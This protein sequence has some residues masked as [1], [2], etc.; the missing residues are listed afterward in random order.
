M[1]KFEIEPA[2]YNNSN[3]NS[4]L[5]SLIR[6]FEEEGLVPCGARKRSAKQVR[7]EVEFRKYLYGFSISLGVTIDS[8]EDIEIR[9]K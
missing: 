1:D 5:R 9:F 7:P 4:E 2:Y 3:G 8:V 6:E